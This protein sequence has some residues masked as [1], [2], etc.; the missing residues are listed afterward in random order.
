MP[1]LSALYR[2]RMLEETNRAYAE[3]HADTES[4]AAEIAER[5]A[6][7]VTLQD[8]LAEQDTAPIHGEPWPVL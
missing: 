2:R 8:G 5:D 6:W 4:W 7:D 1:Q 3:L